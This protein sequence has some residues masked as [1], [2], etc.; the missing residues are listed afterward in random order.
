MVNYE[1][2]SEHIFGW[3]PRYLHQILL[4]LFVLSNCVRM[5][6]SWLILQLAF[7]VSRC[8]VPLPVVIHPRSPL[9][10]LIQ[11]IDVPHPGIFI[12]VFECQKTQW[13]CLT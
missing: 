12:T 8:Y 11:Y 2:I 4:V 3:L 13:T 9:L 5:F 1:N 7:E 10:I 6:I